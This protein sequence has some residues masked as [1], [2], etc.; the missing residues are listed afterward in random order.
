MSAT[1]NFNPRSPHG[2]RLAFCDFSPAQAR[3][4]IHAPRTG[5]D[6][7]SAGKAAGNPEIS[8]HAP[9]TGSDRTRCSSP[10]TRRYFNP[11]SPHGERRRAKA[12]ISRKAISIHAPR[13]GSDY[14][15][16]A[17]FERLHRISIHAPR[18]G[19]DQIPQTTLPVAQHFNPR[20]PHGERRYGYFYSESA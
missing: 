17:F 1:A 9:R 12:R 8:I 19:S 5:S 4:S 3:I 15:V 7:E 20:S 10:T 16:W 14:S 11:R 13:T 2:E 6:G 18:T